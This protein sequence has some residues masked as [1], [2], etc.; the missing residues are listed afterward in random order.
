VGDG[1]TNL[2]D[3]LD[4]LIYQIS[5]EDLANLSH[6]KA[7][8]VLVRE[9]PSFNAEARN[10]LAGLS[11]ATRAAVEA[12][13]P[14]NRPHH[15]VAPSLLGVLSN[16]AITNKHKLLLPV[17]TVPSSLRFNVVTKGPSKGRIGATAGSIEDGSIYFVYETDSPAPGTTLTFEKLEIEIALPHETVAS[18]PAHLSGRSPTRFLVPAMIQEVED[19]VK[20]V[21][22]SL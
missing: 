8:F 10:K 21:R 9:Q 14:Y 1:I 19:A 2:R 17:F 6:P 11:Q 13:Q 20:A 16:F 15:V 3:S 5:N 4:H 12:F 7:A 18:V 22:A